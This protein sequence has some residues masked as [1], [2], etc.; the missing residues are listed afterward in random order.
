MK[1]SV[2]KLLLIGILL[3][4]LL[5]TAAA[6]ADG[7]WV[8]PNCGQEGNT[9]RFCSNC[10][11]A[12]PT[13]TTWTCTNCGQEGNTGTFCTNCGQKKAETSYQVN[14]HLEQI[15]GEQNRV[16]VR[17]GS[18]DAT[19]YIKNKSEPTRW[20]PANVNDN[21]ETT[22]WQ[23]SKKKKNTLK[24]TWIQLDPVAAETVDAVWFKNGF[25]GYNTKG[26]D[27][28]V[29]NA[30]P[31]TVLV[32]FLYAGAGAYTDGVELTLWDDASRSGW[33][34]FDVGHRQNVTSVRIWIRSA[35][36]GTKY[37][38][39]VC[40]SE[41]MLV[42]NAPAYLAREASQAGSGRIYESTASSPV[43]ANLK[44]ELST[45]SG[46]GTEYEGTKNYFKSTWK[47]TTVQVTGKYWDGSIWW[48][49]VDFDYGNA[50]YRVWTGLKRVDVNLDY[51]KEI[52]PKGEGTVSSTNVRRGP[53][54]NYASAPNTP[55]SWVD[56]VA[57]RRETGYVDI[58]YYGDNGT[59]YRGWVPS[60]DAWGISWGTDH[61]GN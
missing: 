49:E 39:D 21:D 26:D 31:K 24:N 58:E 46:P 32:E 59:V 53:G 9:G 61:S 28:Y 12:G 19:S 56:V 40:L 34:S 43:A 15:P 29:I 27:L 48:V 37:P 36:E 8:C 35:Y 60:E 51:V 17:V 23:F 30:R 25:W 45:R 10:G 13:S 2:L 42:Q 6:A 4:G 7:I 47:T 20:L 41:V 16:R 38:N 55:G 3:T 14:D 57:Y 1:H 52:L 54:G 18:V 22:C 44:M 11:Q 50:R 33:Q 5:L